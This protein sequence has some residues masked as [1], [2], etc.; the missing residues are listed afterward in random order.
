MI[1]KKKCHQ[2]DKLKS[3]E[4]KLSKS[5]VLCL[6]TR[7]C[8]VILVNDILVT[9]NSCLYLPKIVSLE[10]SIPIKIGKEKEKKHVSMNND[11]N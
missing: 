4:W 2:N 11:K 7:A 3:K 8:L 5:L 10:S 1:L 9:C 6:L